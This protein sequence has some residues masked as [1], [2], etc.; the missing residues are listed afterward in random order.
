VDSGEKMRFSPKDIGAT[1]GLVIGCTTLRV[2]V[3]V[4]TRAW[5]YS[6]C[7]TGKPYFH[8]PSHSFCF[9]VIE[10]CFSR[11][12]TD[13]RSF[14]SIRGYGALRELHGGAFRPE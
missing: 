10:L 7:V 2:T 5:T 9:L 3:D 6:Q 4:R 13:D 8:Q 11:N 12:R 14:L 1:Y